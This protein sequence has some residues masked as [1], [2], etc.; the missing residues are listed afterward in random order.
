MMPACQRTWA[1]VRADFRRALPGND[2]LATSDT[3]QA[4]ALAL[5]AGLA[6]AAA[7]APGVG[8]AG[9]LAALAPG[10]RAGPRRLVGRLPPPA[11][12]RASR[13][14]TASSSVT[15]SGVL[16]EGSVA[17]TPSWLT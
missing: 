1:R 12:T 17:F 15:V 3:P 2:A 11:A 9:G 7:A 8:P 5:R 13:S 4:P 6:F 10:L 14:A 16:S